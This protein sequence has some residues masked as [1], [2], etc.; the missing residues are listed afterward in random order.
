MLTKTVEGSAGILEKFAPDKPIL[1]EKMRNFSKIAFE[2][3]DSMSKINP[4]KVRLLLLH[5]LKDLSSHVR[6]LI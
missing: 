1:A 4:E 6:C 3:M 5:T 2:V